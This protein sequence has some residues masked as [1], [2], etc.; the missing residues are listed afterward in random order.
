LCQ[1]LLNLPQSQQL[2]PQLMYQPTPMVLQQQRLAH[3]TMQALLP[4]MAVVLV[5]AAAAAQQQQ[6]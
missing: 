3:W 4:V 2:P 6:L 5:L 1:H